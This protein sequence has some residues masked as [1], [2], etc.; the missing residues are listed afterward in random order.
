M[1]PLSP[2]NYAQSGREWFNMI[3]S[4]IEAVRETNC[5]GTITVVMPSY[6]S[7][8][9]T[10]RRLIKLRRG[11]FNVDFVRIDDIASMLVPPDDG[12]KR[13][14]R[15]RTA[16]LVRSVVESASVEDLGPLQ[17]LQ[18]HPSLAAA[19]HIAFDELRP[20]S[21]DGLNRISE[22]DPGVTSA[23]VRLW[24]AFSERTR[25]YAD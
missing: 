24:R 14:T 5:L 16:E 13:L 21:E 19:L 7:A 18:G 9:Y 23:V 22:T 15:L 20:V 11:L 8:F 1:R 17:Q 4:R 2:V 25:D 12:S 6:F 3:Y 10:R